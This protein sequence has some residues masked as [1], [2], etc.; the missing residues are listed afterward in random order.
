MR[1][2]LHALCV[3]RIQKHLNRIDRYCYWWCWR[4]SVRCI[5]SN[6]V[7]R[8]RIQI[9]IYKDVKALSI[10]CKNSHQW[11]FC[12]FFALFQMQDHYYEISV[13]NCVHF[14][15]YQ[16]MNDL[17]QISSEIDRFARIHPDR[18]SQTDVYIHR[19]LDIN[20]GPIFFNFV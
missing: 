1:L 19:W 2:S 7:K 8:S 16:Q 17:M 3:I 18:N 13:V 6:D 10:R 5:V 11:K 4:C 12:F 15:V 9:I 20:I 14:S